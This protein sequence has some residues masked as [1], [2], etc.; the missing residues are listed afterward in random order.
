GIKGIGFALG[1]DR[2]IDAIQ[3][4]KK[5]RATRPVDVFIAWMGER[6]Y[7]T[8]VRLARVLRDEKHIVE[9]PPTE[10]KFRKAL[11]RADKAGARYVL[12]IGDDEIASK[13]LTIKHL[14][15]GKQEKIS[16]EALVDYFRGE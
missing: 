7:P 10:M 16:E 1:E 3:E 15:D 8:A 12:I 9:L 14:A 2:F 4:A 11:E 13:Q 6:A 5:I